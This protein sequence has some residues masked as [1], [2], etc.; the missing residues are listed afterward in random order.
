MNQLNMIKHFWL[1]AL[2]LMFNLNCLKM[3]IVQSL[4]L[5]KPF[6]TYREQNKNIKYDLYY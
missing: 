5:N 1:L 4:N 3:T 6:L 2:V